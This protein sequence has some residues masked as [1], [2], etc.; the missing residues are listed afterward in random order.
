LQN[1]VAAADAVP[2]GTADYDQRMGNGD[3]STPCAKTKL[4]IF[5]YCARPA[6]KLR[7]TSGSWL[8]SSDTMRLLFDLFDW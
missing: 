5:I 4:G 1:E 8:L 2:K 3:T 7:N 6:P